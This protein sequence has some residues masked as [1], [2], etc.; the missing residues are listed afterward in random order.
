[1]AITI[2]GSANTIAGVAVGGLPNGIVDND[3]L[4][5]NAV[6]SAKITDGTIAA[7]DLASGAAVPADGSITAAKLADNAV[8]TAKIVDNALTTAKIADN[9]VTSAKATG[10]GGITVC[11]HWYLASST[12][13]GTNGIIA[14]SN[15]A[16]GGAWTKYASS[17]SSVTTVTTGAGGGKFSFPTTGMYLIMGNFQTSHN[18][19]D[20]DMGLSASITTDNFSS[21]SLLG[22]VRTT[23]N[24]TGGD[25]NCYHQG[26]SSFIFDVTDTSNCK[27]YFSQGSVASNNR[28]Y[29]GNSAG[30]GPFATTCII[31]RLGDT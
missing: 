10:V 1:M 22:Y 8:T 23:F 31:M 17:T 12:S 4:A 15:G 21:T 20:N 30:D 19:D 16:G 25:P 5:A 14:D 6:T 18:S 7:G 29:G 27:F 2:N 11:D 13:N 9:A 24:N 3:T 26:S 28:V